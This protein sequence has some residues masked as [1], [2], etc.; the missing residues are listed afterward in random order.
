MESGEG[1]WL[2]KISYASGKLEVQ[3][4]SNNVVAPRGEAISLQTVLAE[5]ESVFRDAKKQ[6]SIRRILYCLHKE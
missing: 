2:N 1:K 6:A 3:Q 5:A 4:Q